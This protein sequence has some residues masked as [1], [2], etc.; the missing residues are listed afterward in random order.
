MRKRISIDRRT[1]TLS[2]AALGATAALPASAASPDPNAHRGPIIIS[3]AAGHL[4]ERT[5]R[6]LLARGIPASALILVTRTPERL[7][8]YA[9][10]GSS[11]RY[12][13]FTRPESLP[14]AF[15]GGR[16]MLLISIG[17]GP[18]PR[19]VAHENAIDAAKAAGVEHIAYT[20]WIGLT[21]GDRSGLGADHYRTE[22]ALKRSGVAWTMLRNSIYMEILLRQAR[23]MIA[24]GRAG[25]PRHE[26]R[27]VYV[28]R[29]DCAAA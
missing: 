25:V 22:Q 8:S 15:A 20:S 4:G 23:N 12:G 18:M 26:D 7:Q 17:F 24:A 13:D 6:A 5:V 1:F 16:Q 21:R 29:A 19:P 11:V 9:Q 3:G 27:L 10:Q 28:A 2:V 14:A